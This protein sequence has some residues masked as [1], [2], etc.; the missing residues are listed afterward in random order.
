MAILL[1][2]SPIVKYVAKELAEGYNIEKSSPEKR[3]IA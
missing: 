2:F 1:Y 3:I